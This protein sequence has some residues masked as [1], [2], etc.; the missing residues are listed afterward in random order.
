MQGGRGEERGARL[1]QLDEE[2][3]G[4]AK[5]RKIQCYMGGRL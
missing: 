2:Q 5:R 3:A 4:G 1:G